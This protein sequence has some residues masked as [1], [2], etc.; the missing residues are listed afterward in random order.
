MAS[1]RKPHILIVDDDT[2]NLDLLRTQLGLGDYAITCARGGVAGLAAAAVEPPDLVV[3]DVMMPDLDGYEMVRRLKSADDTRAVPVLLVTSTNERRE[4]IEGLAAGA[5]DF[6]TRP[7]ETAELLARVRSLLRSKS[8][9]DQLQVLNHELEQRVA[10]RTAQL[11]ATVRELEMFA[12]SISHDLRAPLRGMDG[13]SQALLEDYAADLDPRAAEYLSRVRAAGQRM[14]QMIDDLLKLS[15]LGRAPVRSEPVHLSRIAQSVVVEL[16]HIEPG[17]AVMI[18]IES[19]LVALGD[20]GL[21]RLVYQNLLGNAWKFTR[22]QPVGEI[23]VGSSQDGETTA[24]FVRDN[25]VGFD[26]AYATKL[27]GVFQRL[28]AASEFEGNGIGLATVQRVIHRHGGRVWA[29]STPGAGSTLWFSLD[30]RQ[31]E[32]PTSHG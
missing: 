3:S 23:E 17:R 32:V 7:I 22:R 13:F 31:E 4:Q 20:H 15:R 5:D 29:E 11:S 10:D 26:M 8:L 9:Y 18:T 19:D 12:Y 27:F 2:I 25:G 16:A 24:Y 21:L 1:P 28:H 30:G 14:G 6:L